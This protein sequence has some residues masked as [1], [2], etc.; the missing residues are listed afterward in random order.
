MTSPK[1]NLTLYKTK[2]NFESTPEPTGEQSQHKNTNNIFVVQQH[3]ARSMHYDFRLEINGVLVSWAVPK[4]P[5]IDPKIKRLAIRTEDHPLDY[6]GFEGFIPEGNYGAGT[7]IVWD[8][9][10]YTNLKTDVTM[11]ESLNRG[12]ITIQLHGKKLKGGFALIKTR[13]YAQGSWL[14]VKMRDEQAQD[15]STITTHAPKSVL[16]NTTIK[17]LEKQ[18]K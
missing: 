16:S 17:D 7:V 15:K 5:S 4:G 14:L 11:Q 9:G 12:E 10:M 1:K 3:D 18:K 8:T 6:A 13:L 2:R